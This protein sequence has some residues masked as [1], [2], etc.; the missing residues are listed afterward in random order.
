MFRF[1]VRELLM[2]TA[3]VGTLVG[4]G[5]DHCRLEAERKHAV[6]LAEM[7][8]ERFTVL[9]YIHEHGKLPPDFWESG[10]ICYGESLA[11]QVESP[12]DAEIE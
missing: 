11:R 4:W 3:F 6:D 1:T 5:L 7:A 2:A 10:F 12:T 9:H 8:V